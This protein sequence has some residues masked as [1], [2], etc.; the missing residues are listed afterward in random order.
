MHV[1]ETELL[2]CLTLCICLGE[3]ST[4]TPVWL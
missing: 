1:E 4:K 3:T 2:E